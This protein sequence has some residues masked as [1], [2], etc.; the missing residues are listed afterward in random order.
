[1]NLQIQGLRGLAVLLVIFYH[2]K[3]PLFN[4]GYIGVDIFFVISGYVITKL[5]LKKLENQKLDLKRFYQNRM[6][7]LIPNLIVV[8]TITSIFA[9]LLGNPLGFQQEVA[10]S[11]ITSILGI[12]NLYLMKSTQNYFGIAA[13]SNP[14][15]HMWSLGVEFQFYI[16]FPVFLLLFNKKFKSFNLSLVILISFLLSLILNVILLTFSEPLIQ[17]ISFFNPGYRAWEF[18]AGVLIASLKDNKYASLNH[19]ATS[20]T[21]YLLIIA[22]LFVE[23]SENPIFNQIAIRFFAVIGAALIVFSSRFQDKNNFLGTNFM[24]YIG[25]RSYSLY[26]WHWPTLVFCN[27]VMAN[28]LSSYIIAFILMTFLSLLSYRL[29]EFP[30]Y[31]GKLNS[32]DFNKFLIIFLPIPLTLSLILGLNA[33]YLLYPEFNKPGKF[34]YSG[35]VANSNKPNQVPNKFITCLTQGHKIDCNAS[36]ESFILLLGDSHAGSLTNTLAD[37]SE[38]PLK[39]LN[40]KA[41][42]DSRYEDNLELIF[43]F[44]NLEKPKLIVLAANWDR[45]GLSS[46]LPS[47]LSR[48]NDLDFKLFV[49]EDNPNFK[50]DAFTCAYGVGIFVGRNKCSGEIYPSNFQLPLFIRHYKNIEYLSVKKYFCQFEDCS[51][52]RGKEILYFDS[53]HLN[54]I[55]ASYLLDKLLDSNPKFAT[56]FQRR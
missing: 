56:S 47:F 26:L 46:G 8:V 12:N 41:F 16:L 18:L 48:V 53:H 31:K 9:Y 32:I 17:D 1:L 49:L 14:L 19:N 20:I 30:F 4:S 37:H 6:R 33:K 36:P 42:S 5:L 38:F 35:Q 43:N 54:S 7:R 27:N 25:N 3:I 55:G 24:V 10:K 52:V 28:E 2:F 13:D 23:L 39:Y 11:G 51:M 22:A 15:I 21:G 50:F 40:S 34:L 44:I 29:V 45:L